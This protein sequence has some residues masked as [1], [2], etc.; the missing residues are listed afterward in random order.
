[1]GIGFG[2]SC[3]LQIAGGRGVFNEIISSMNFLAISHTEMLEWYS[4]TSK[5]HNRLDFKEMAGLFR[6]CKLNFQFPIQYSF[7]IHSMRG[8]GGSLSIKLF[9]KVTDRI[10]YEPSKVSSFS[11]PP[12]RFS[13]FQCKI[14]GLSSPF[15]QDGDGF[16]YRIHTFQSRIIG[17]VVSRKVRQDCNECIHFQFNSWLNSLHLVKTV[18]LL[19]CERHLCLQSI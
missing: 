18:H 16:I 7:G 8:G 6:Q 14:Y 2:G 13:S 4:L 15:R 3:L 11:S 5:V 1:M 9:L 17:M 10:T 12:S 19:K